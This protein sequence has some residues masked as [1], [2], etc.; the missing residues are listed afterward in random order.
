MAALPNART[1]AEILVDQLINHGVTHVFCVPGESYLAVLDAFH[2]RNISV[3]VCRQEGGAAMMAEA[4]GKATGRP[5]VCFVTRGPGATNASIGVHIAQQD[6]TPMILFVGQVERKAR[7][8][9]A[10]QEVDYPAMFGSMTKWTAEIEDASRMPELISRAFHAATSG[11][12]GP[13]VIS[14]PEDMLTDLADV[15]DAPV[16]EPVETSPGAGDLAKLQALLSTAQRP[17]LLMGGSRWNAQ[18]RDAMTRFAENFDIPVMTSYRRMSLFD[19][20]HRLYAGDLGIGPNP[21][22]IARIKVCDLLIVA[23]G[24]LG[25][26]P[27]QGYTLFDLPAPAQ[28]IVH[29]HAEP[30]ELG[31]VFVPALAINATP[32]RFAPALAALEPPAS[33]AWAG[34]AKEAR[35][36]YCG[37]TDVAT[38]QPGG[39][40]FG[41][42]MVWLRNNIPADT[43][44]C[45]GAGNFA[46]WIHRFYRFRQFATHMAPAAGA[47]G[48]GVPA[49]VAMKRLYPG[50]DI[51]CLAGDGDFL[52]NGQEFATAVQYDLPFV[53]IICDNG[54]YG[55][56]RMHQER[57][58]PGRISA[59]TLRNP[60]FSAYARAFGGFG[61]RVDRT[62]DFAASYHA[63]KASGVPAIIHLKIDSEAILPGMTLTKIREQALKTK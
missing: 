39:V 57:E 1:G 34:S 44:L 29:F 36:D 62:E 40:N 49:A 15:A 22:L 37:W 14:L 38:P 51:L 55:T 16:F 60:D 47:M 20:H 54:L 28:R 50:R 58:Y 10:F 59:T 56:I 19:S 17:L 9:D 63:A 11:R 12:P 8:R 2:D 48:Y 25:D 18:A 31:R 5:G 23:G 53:T 6:S 61:V 43:I 52:M 27:S 45:N 46:T 4:V 26:I 33:P 30:E 35:R 42:I 21:A 24:R 13:V 32:Q 7:G 41:E 3:T